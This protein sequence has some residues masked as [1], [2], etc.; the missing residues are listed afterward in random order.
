MNAIKYKLPEF[1]DR[2]QRR[3]RDLERMMH[4][5]FIRAFL[6]EHG[7]DSQ[8]I[9]ENFLE[10]LKIDEDSYVCDPCRSLE[11]CPKFTR[12]MRLV[13]VINAD[14]SI[15]AGHAPCSKMQAFK[16]IADNYRIRDF[17]NS[18][19]YTTSNDLNLTSP[20]AKIVYTHLSHRLDPDYVGKGVML[21]GA[22]G[23]GKT[24]MM[25]ALAN[26]VA[27]AGHSVAFIS[28][29][30]LIAKVATWIKEKENSTIDEALHDLATVDFLI[31]DDL[32]REQVSVPTRDGFLLE[33]I[34]RR[35]QSG[36][37]NVFATSSRTFAQL[38]HDYE[39]FKDGRQDRLMS[40]LQE[41]MDAVEYQGTTKR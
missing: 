3:K 11:S 22:S 32:G 31:L 13:P 8:A 5:P 21:H 16:A 1:Q 34:E 14:G 28:V 33:L 15:E 6:V 24:F 10:F 19:I 36:K 18:L 17:D 37:M 4:N 12:G 23:V 9:D 35:I 26:E 2:E 30:R 20:Y 7:L 27:K 40:R 25:I 29:K 39:L 38:N 41:A